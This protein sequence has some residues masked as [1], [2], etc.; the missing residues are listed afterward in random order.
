[1]PNDPAPYIS[2]QSLV[3]R[4]SAKE[5]GKRGRYQDVCEITLESVREDARAANLATDVLWTLSA[6]KEATVHTALW[7]DFPLALKAFRFHSTSRR[8]HGKMGLPATS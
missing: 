8:K 3:Q 7:H 2:K 5:G 4:Q 6:G 1:M